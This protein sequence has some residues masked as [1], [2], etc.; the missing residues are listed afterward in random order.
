MFTRFDKIHERDRHPNK[1][2]DRLHTTPRLCI[3]L[4]GE[5]HSLQL[6]KR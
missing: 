2:T 3:A 4:R 1:Q 6:V 5:N